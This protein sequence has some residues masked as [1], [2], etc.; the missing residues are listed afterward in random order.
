MHGYEIQ[1]RSNSLKKIER[2]TVCCP[3][4]DQIQDKEESSLVHEE[5]NEKNGII[6]DLEGKEIESQSVFTTR[7]YFSND[8]KVDR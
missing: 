7:N 8:K 4:E 6:L 1:L 5:I 3:R 2:G